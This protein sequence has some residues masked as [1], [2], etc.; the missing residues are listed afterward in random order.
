M[1]KQL[2]FLFIVF[3]LTHHLTAQITFTD[4]YD[5]DGAA[6]EGAVSFVIDGIAYIGLGQVGS[7]QYTKSFYRYNKGKDD[8]GFTYFR[9]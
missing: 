3:Q 6:R 8:Y 9:W 7:N 1:K 2:L 5:F 4:L